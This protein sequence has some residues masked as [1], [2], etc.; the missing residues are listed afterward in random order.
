MYQHE[1]VFTGAKKLNIFSSISRFACQMSLVPHDSMIADAPTKRHGNS[2]TM[3]RVFKT[4][5]L[6]IVALDDGADENNVDPRPHRHHEDN[7]A[8]PVDWCQRFAVGHA[9]TIPWDPDLQA[10]LLSVREKHEIKNERGSEVE[11]GR[12]QS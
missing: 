10:D 11:G 3:L 6:S 12:L 4:D 5:T 2:V 9:K 1:N 7:V 8:G